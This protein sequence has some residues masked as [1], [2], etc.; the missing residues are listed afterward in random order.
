[1][2][3]TRSAT[4]ARG[5]PR[6]QRR[7]A[8]HPPPQGRTPKARSSR[9][10]TATWP[11]CWA[12]EGASA[13]SPEI[14]VLTG[15]PAVRASAPLAAIA[16]PT[17]DHGPV[18]PDG[19]VRVLAAGPREVPSIFAVLPKAVVHVGDV[20]DQ[21]VLGELS[22]ERLVPPSCTPPGPSTRAGRPSSGVSTTQAPRPSSRPPSTPGWVASSIYRP[23][24]LRQRRDPDDASD[25]TS[26]IAPTWDMEC[27]DARRARGARRP[28]PATSPRDRQ[29][30]WFY[31]PGNPSDSHV[32]LLVAAGRFPVPGDGS[33][34]RSMVFIDNL[35]QGSPW[36]SGIPPRPGRRSGWP[37]VTRAHSGTSSTPAPG[38][39]R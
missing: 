33:Q 8:P 31:G 18:G 26:L 30:P 24:R 7:F 2:A 35:V 23:T 22:A 38:A 19:Q 12:D 16:R 39:R 17:G 21:S 27:Q 4:S 32:L 37:T 28:R 9:S 3:L 6:G 11:R 1:M 25:S 14:T 36:P 34:R 13:T 29:A 10:P 15:G 20:T 5:R